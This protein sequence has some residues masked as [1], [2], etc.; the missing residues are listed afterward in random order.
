MIVHQERDFRKLYKLIKK[1]HP[2]LGGSDW[3]MKRLNQARDT[4]LG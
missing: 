4:L 3:I 2:D 1:N